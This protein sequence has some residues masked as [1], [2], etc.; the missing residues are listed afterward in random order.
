MP[1]R[2]R[3][4]RCRWRGTKNCAS[5]GNQGLVCVHGPPKADTHIHCGGP[6][7]LRAGYREVAASARIGPPLRR[8]PE[9]R[10]AEGAYRKPPRL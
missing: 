2:K 6:P 10:S 5:M 7:E 9:R 1:C 8:I 4:S 3:K